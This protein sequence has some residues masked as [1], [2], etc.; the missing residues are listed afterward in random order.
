MHY[1]IAEIKDT[2]SGFWA[3]LNKNG[4]TY[5]ICAGCKDFEKTCSKSFSRIED[6]EAVFNSM[7]HCIIHGLFSLE[8]RLAMLS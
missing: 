6:A 5:T 2:H 7:S 8:D 1:T 3:D 4:N